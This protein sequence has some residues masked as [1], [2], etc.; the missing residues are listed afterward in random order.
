[1]H[2]ANL[3]MSNE[4]PRRD[5]PAG[6]DALVSVIIPTLNEADNLPLLVPQ[7]GSALSEIPYEILVV[8]DNSADATLEICATLAQAFPVRLI[9]RSEPKDGLSGAVLEGMRCADGDV[10]V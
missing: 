3:K 5:N 2:A 1:M 4:R 6:A 9:V 10:F 8:D 7:I